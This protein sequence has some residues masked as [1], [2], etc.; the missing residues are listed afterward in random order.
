MTQLHLKSGVI[1]HKVVY[2]T[3]T[4]V[5]TIIGIYYNNHFNEVCCLVVYDT[6]DIIDNKITDFKFVHHEG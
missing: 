1:G 4:T 6:G 3:Q 5:G 2:G